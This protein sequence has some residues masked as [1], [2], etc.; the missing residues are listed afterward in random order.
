MRIIGGKW[1]GRQLQ[2]PQPGG[3]DI[4]PTSDR[5]RENLFNILTSKLRDGFNDLHVADLCAGTGALGFEAL[6]R[7]AAHVHFVDHN[8][9]AC[10]LI[11]VSAKKLDCAAQVS[12]IQSDARKLPPIAHRVGL[13]FLDPPYA[14][15]NELEIIARAQARDW[16]GPECIMMIEAARAR[17]FEWKSTGISQIDRRDYG[18]TSL[19]FFKVDGAPP[20][21]PSPLEGE[22]R[23]EG[24]GE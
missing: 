9:A 11:K 1:R 10:D 15:E 18:K 16:L 7:G 6:S 5:I 4:R 20:S 13:L 8:R 17:N 23:G 19:H 3:L 21:S 24:E 2:S 12:I 14:D 22:G